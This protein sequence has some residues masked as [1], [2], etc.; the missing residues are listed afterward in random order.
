[1]K[2]NINLIKDVNV[3]H[4]L[5][6]YNKNADIKLNSSKYQG[7][8][9]LKI[10]EDC[11]YIN[12]FKVDNTERASKVDDLSGLENLYIYDLSIVGVDLSDCEFNFFEDH[13]RELELSY[14]NIVDISDLKTVLS[15][16]MYVN[17]SHNKIRDISAFKDKAFDMRSIINL[18]LSYN[19]IKYISSLY[20]YEKLK[21]L[22]LS[23][24]KIE[25]L[26]D[27]KLL[28]SLEELNISD[29]RI[30]NIEPLLA[31]SHLKY[32]D[33]TKN[34]IEDIEDILFIRN[35]LNVK[36]DKDNLKYISINTENNSKDVKKLQ[37]LFRD[38][39]LPEKWEILDSEKKSIKEI[40]IKNKIHDLHPLRDFE[41]NAIAESIDDEEDYV[42]YY[43]NSKCIVLANLS[44][45][46][47]IS[48]NYQIGFI[49]FRDNRELLDYIMDGNY[50]VQNFLKHN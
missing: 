1:M 37:S 26:M 12:D 25:E 6:E 44:I 38:T 19:R 28:R 16:T 32:L 30:K 13:Y 4:A 3:L 24:N 8:D 33:I 31:L 14:L 45:H 20:E 15:S 42:I 27:F 7:L 47:Y 23:S 17:L 11:I 9:S 2:C 41:L 43:V 35:L 18:D 21:I 29:N 48:D 5:N 39:Y 10:R 22:N 49:A 40:E 34:D 50:V 46:E 36:Y